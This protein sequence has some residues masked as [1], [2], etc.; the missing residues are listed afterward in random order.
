MPSSDRALVL[1]CRHP[2]GGPVKTRLARAIGADGA[3]ELYAAFLR[4]TLT[5]A[6][7]PQP[8][9][10]LIALA[11]GRHRDG[12]AENFSVHPESIFAQDGNDLGARISHSF[13]AA[14]ARDYRRVAV[15]ASDAPELTA[16]DVQAALAALDEYN[17]VLIPASD[18]G[19][20]LMALGQLVDVF[21]GVTWSTSLVLDQ[22]LDLARGGYWSV[23][24]LR[25][26][27]DIDDVEALEAFRARLSE[28]P[29]LCRRLP[30]TTYQLFGDVHRHP[31]DRASARRQPAAN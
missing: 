26:V 8:F 7:A 14:F 31:A 30:R 16:E 9:D 28:S 18:G 17:I 15:A 13:E 27:A 29:E 4:D 3:A 19:W 20:S 22:T 23:A 12:F 2:Y 10:L 21:S 5:W 25:T 1:F 6:S 24:L 11:D